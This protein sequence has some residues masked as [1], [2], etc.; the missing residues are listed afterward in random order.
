MSDLTIDHATRRV[1][2]WGAASVTP[3]KFDLPTALSMEAGRVLAYDQIPKWVWSLGM[4][5]NLR[6]LRIHP[7]QLRH[8]LGE[9]ADTRRKS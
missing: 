9:N 4:L 3:N 5:G 1:T 2:S 7:M 6:V 8:K